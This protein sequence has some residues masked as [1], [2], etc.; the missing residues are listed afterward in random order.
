MG[1]M[2]TV[3]DFL[4][5]RVALAI[6]AFLVGVL[7]LG[8]VWA[9][10]SAASQPEAGPPLPIAGP[11]TSSPAPEPGRTSTVAPTVPAVP[12]AE[13]GCPRA[14]RTVSS[15]EDLHG[16]L[17]GASPGDVIVLQPGSYIGNFIAT[18]SGTPGSPITLCG[19]AQSVLDGDN[20]KGDY[21]LHLDGA[22][23][24]HLLGFAVT[25][26][27]KGVMADGTVGSVIEGLR[28]FHIGDEAIHL[29]NFSTDNTVIGND[30]SDTGLRRP[31]FGEGVYIGTA[32]SN[33][34]DISNCQPDNS[35][36]NLVAD[37]V[38][39]GTTSESVDIKEG[40]TGGV[41]R[42]N[43]F[44]GSSII[45]ADSW[46][47]VK[48]NDWVIENNTGVNSPL[49]GFQTHEIV[50]GWGTRNVFR[51]NVAT[52]NGEGF[53]FSLTPQRDNVVSCSNTV[54]Q[55]AEGFSNVT[56]SD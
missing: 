29:R 45:D 46:V 3:R 52:V 35:D 25:N 11:S 12:S 4:K 1:D 39:H 19:S 48:G 28:V 18:V 23:Y 51:N 14:T 20:W 43:S 47:D 27:Q 55:A 56:C 36:R 49:D 8:T 5:T 50:D 15:A 2:S 54:T 42:G 41:V 9:L 53:G 34:C 30:I 7:A 38:I 32:E 37:N 17:E 24:W 44:D 16:A 13:Q 31:K 21:V 26:G 22:Q 10:V 6:A 40:T 33:W